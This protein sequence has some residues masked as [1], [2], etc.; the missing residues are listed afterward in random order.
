MICSSVLFKN[1][2]IH[3]DDFYFAGFGGGNYCT[4][5][6]VTKNCPDFKDSIK[7]SF[8][9]KYIRKIVIIVVMFTFSKEC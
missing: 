5:E 4:N 3:Q 1:R 7:Y 9:Q 2:Y 6:I 8:I